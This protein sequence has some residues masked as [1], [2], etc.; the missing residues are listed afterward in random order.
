MKKIWRVEDKAGRGCYQYITG[1]K[2][3]YDIIIEHSEITPAQHPTPINDTGIERYIRD[4]EICGFLTRE[5]AIQW[6]SE[7]DLKELGEAGFELKEVEVAEITAIG[8][9]Q[10][11]AIRRV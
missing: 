11:L 10:V 1:H 6:F 7:R 8:E 4:I 2:H 5:Q 3:H 9:K